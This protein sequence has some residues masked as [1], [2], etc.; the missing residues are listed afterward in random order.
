[1]PNDEIS[2]IEKL[3][4][5]FDYVVKDAIAARVRLLKQRDKGYTHWTDSGYIE[6][7]LGLGIDA[8]TH[9]LDYAQKRAENDQN[10]AK[11]K[12]YNEAIARDPSIVLDPTKLVALMDKCKMEVPEALRAAVKPTAVAA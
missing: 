11:L 9:S 7:L 10:A 1:M 3:G 4:V 5:P 12:A 6:H 8:R 2:V